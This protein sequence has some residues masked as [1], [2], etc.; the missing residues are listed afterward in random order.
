MDTWH[1]DT[2]WEEFAATAPCLVR[3]EWI[4]AFRTN[5]YPTPLELFHSS[6]DLHKLDNYC[7]IQTCIRFLRT[8]GCPLYH[9]EIRALIGVVLFGECLPDHQV[10]DTRDPRK[11]SPWLRTRGG[12]QWR[13]NQNR[14]DV[15]T[16]FLA[17]SSQDIQL[18]TEWLARI[19]QRTEKLEAN[20]WR[21]NKNKQQD[22]REKLQD[23]GRQLGNVPGAGE[24]L[25]TFRRQQEE[26]Q[27]EEKK[28][29]AALARVEPRLNITLR[30]E[31][32]GPGGMYPRIS[33][34]WGEVYARDGKALISHDGVEY[35]LERAIAHDDGEHYLGTPL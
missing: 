25:A 26:K 12:M 1:C 3:P 19:R 17:A 31:T 35:K 9:E 24:E 20:K 28:N 27:E 22:T 4:T 30:S 32:L 34:R 14:L 18:A 8:Q 2:T 23:I 7:P 6:A 11:D 21:R 5:S 16:A 33:K 10:W 13:A 15:A 29:V